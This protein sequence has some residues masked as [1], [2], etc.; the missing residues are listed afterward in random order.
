MR[1]ELLKGREFES[2]EKEMEFL[3]GKKVL[4]I[5]CGAGIFSEGLGRL[6]L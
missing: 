3:K 1:K 2:L 6:G 5:G 4:D